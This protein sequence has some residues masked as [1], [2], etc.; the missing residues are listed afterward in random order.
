LGHEAKWEYFRVMYERYCRTEGK[1]RSRILD[2]FCLTTA[3]NRKYAIRRLNGPPPEKQRVKRAR[4]RKPRY[5]KP[6][7]TV[8]TAA[9]K[10]A[11]NSADGE[12]A[13]TLNLTD[14]HRGWTESRALLGKSEIAVRQALNEIQHIQLTR[15]RLYKKDDNAHI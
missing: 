6:V 2:E 8:L 1:S 12:F 9:W 3:Y 13:H 7:I 11:G 10:A 4:G 14:I 5:G 15:G